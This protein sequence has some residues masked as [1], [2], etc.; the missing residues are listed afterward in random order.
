[1]LRRATI[2]TSTSAQ[3]NLFLPHRGTT[4][5]S[6]HHW[7]MCVRVCVHATMLCV[8]IFVT[9]IAGHLFP[10]GDADKAAEQVRSLATDP[11]AR[12]QMGA[13]ARSEVEKFGWSAAT[14]TLREQQYSRAIRMSRGRQR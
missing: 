9:L 4:R 8:R 3:A 6:H 11:T 12:E 5:N 1:M 7:N 14:K 10:P 13:A 2:Y